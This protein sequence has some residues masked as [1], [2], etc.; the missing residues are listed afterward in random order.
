[1]INK[2][3]YSFEELL[4]YMSMY[5]K[6]VIKWKVRLTINMLIVYFLVLPVATNKKDGIYF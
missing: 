4:N 5:F 1:M 6:F 3:N 2:I